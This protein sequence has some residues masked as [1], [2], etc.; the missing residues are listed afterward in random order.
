MQESELSSVTAS[1]SKSRS[2]LISE[3]QELRDDLQKLREAL[4]RKE[5]EHIDQ[6][7]EVQGE[8]E[9]GREEEMEREC[10]Y[11]IAY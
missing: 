6:L 11:F 1:Y 7:K 3:L 4:T 5:R 9:E 8:G 10:I 2:S